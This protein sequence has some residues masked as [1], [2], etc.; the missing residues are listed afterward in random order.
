MNVAAAAAL[1]LLAMPIVACG[2]SLHLDD[3]GRLVKALR[4]AGELDPGRGL[5]HV[6]HSCDLVIDGKRYP[7]VD[8]REL[9]RGAST[10]RGVNRV[11]VLSPSLQPVYRIPYGRERPLACLRNRL[12]L[13]GAVAPDGIGAEGNVLAFSEGGHRVK[14]ENLDINDWPIFPTARSAGR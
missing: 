6:S 4:A 9:V 12:Y 7:V 14:V 10:P 2:G 3:R 1:A 11:V 8:V 5:S 13:D